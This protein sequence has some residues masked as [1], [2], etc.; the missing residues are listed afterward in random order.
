MLRFEKMLE[1]MLEG[2]DQELRDSQPLNSYYRM[3]L[4]RMAEVWDFEHNT[5]YIKGSQAQ[6][7]SLKQTLRSA[8]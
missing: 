8:R 1:G 5:C 6:G 2:N 3:L 4:H 7:V